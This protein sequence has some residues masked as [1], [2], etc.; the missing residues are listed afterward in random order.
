M[1]NFPY[2]FKTL[3]TT[4]ATQED[5]SN[6]L[7]HYQTWAQIPRVAIHILHAFIGL[8]F[9][10]MAIKIYKPDDETK[11]F[12]Y[13]TLLLYVVAVCIYLTNLKIGAESA[14]AG[15]WGDVDQN[16]GLNVIA[17]SETMILFLLG[18]I[19]AL[20]AGLYW[21]QVDYAQRLEQFEKEG[22][23]NEDVEAKKDNSSATEAPIKKTVKKTGSETK[24]PQKSVKS[25]TKKN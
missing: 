21:A 5:F 18:F 6:S 8:G 25:R 10:G 12:E 13:G 23:E 4:G 24:A 16:T 1:G 14:L 20:Q 3:Y 22:A 15:Q 17:A 7:R 9:V 19:I 11:Y 2:D